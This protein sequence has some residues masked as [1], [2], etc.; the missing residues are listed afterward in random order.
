MEPTAAARAAADAEA[1]CGQALKEEAERLI[2]WV[3]AHAAALL[4]AQFGSL[5]LLLWL[6]LGAFL[7]R[8][9]VPVWLT[10]AI[11]WSIG[12]WGMVWICAAAILPAF[13]VKAG[14]A[15]LVILVLFVTGNNS[16]RVRGALAS[17]NSVLLQSEV[18]GLLGVNA[19]IL[20]AWFYFTARSS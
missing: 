10:S 11:G 12:G 4:L 13:G 5:L 20:L 15:L 17:G 2:R 14:V 7:E 9:R 3:L 19:G 16:R 8:L 18:G 1:L 6:P